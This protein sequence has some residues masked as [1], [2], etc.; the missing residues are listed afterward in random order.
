MCGIAGIFNTDLNNEHDT[1]SLKAMLAALQHRGPDEW[2]LFTSGRM[3]LG[4]VRLSIIDLKHGQ[5]PMTSDR[6]A[7]IYNGEIYNYV[8]LRA[9]LSA[10]G[11]KFYSDSDTE[12][13]LRCFEEYGTDCFAKF[14]G[15]FALLIWD[16][17]QQRLYAARDRY[18]IRPLYVLNFRKKIYFA[19][20]LK[21]FDLIP[22]YYREIDV[23]NLYEHALL[24]NTL[25]DRTV[26]KNVRSIESGTFEVYAK[27]TAV[28]ISRYYQLGEIGCSGSIDYAAARAEFSELLEDSVAMRLRSDVPVAAYLSGGVDSSV[29]AFLAHKLMQ[30][31]LHTFSVAFTDKEY[32]ESG[33]QQEMAARINNKHVAVTVTDD[34]ISENFI[35]AAGHFERPVF[36]TAAVP[37]FLL[38]NAVNENGIK[39]VLTGEA[40]DEILF[41]YDSFKEIKLLQQWKNGKDSDT[42]QQIVK[43][44]YP[45][46][47]HYKDPKKQGFIKMYYESFVDT[48]DNDLV[49]LN[50]RIANN[51]IIQSFIN[52]DHK[53]ADVKQQLPDRVKEILPDNWSSWSLLQKNQFLEMKTLLQGYLLSSQADRM[54]MA[55][56][57]EGRYPFLDHRL[58]DKVFCYDDSFKLNGFSQKHIL[59]DAYRDF[60][61]ASI[62]DRPKKPY[63]A[64]DLKAFFKDGNLKQQTA[65]FLSESSLNETGIFDAKMVQRFLKKFSRGIPDEIGYRDNMLITFILST[66]LLCLKKKNKHTLDESRKSVEIICE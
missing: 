42:M 44:L 13:V 39:V 11:I 26:F 51:N 55:H 28:T 33:F 21:A 40:A 38:S 20:E 53:I 22:D 48:I 10:R 59:R 31:R 16:K 12:V 17:Q 43:E 47:L 45:H 8:E 64:P 58:V 32:D 25:A 19:S 5:Q 66:Q 65:Q 14:N 61:P 24:W 57:V 18:G 49:G 56:S 60:V 62:I 46:L 50:I 29:T 1:A 2:G 52:K 63:T 27:D 34:M 23:E 35:E 37:L 54:S 30:E 41:G 9:E 7:L 4:H 15:Q 36:R 3:L 6:Y